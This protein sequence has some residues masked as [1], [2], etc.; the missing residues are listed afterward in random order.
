MKVST[1]DF[2]SIVPATQVSTNK[3]FKHT[4]SKA[5][6]S[7]DKYSNE[8]AEAFYACQLEVAKA[9]YAAINRA[10]PLLERKTNPKLNERALS[11]QAE[12][13]GFIN[14]YRNNVRNEI[15][16]FAVLKKH[17][18]PYFDE[19]D[20]PTSD[21]RKL[22]TG[23]FHVYRK[24]LID[25]APLLIPVDEVDSLITVINTVFPDELARLEHHLSFYEADC[26][27]KTEEE[28]LNR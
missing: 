2:F 4:K 10:Y 16:P 19:E 17:P 21:L 27:Y 20:R 18:E 12:V 6:V 15:L 11:A 13:K 8:I 5:T 14:R 22:I 7:L 26:R 23:Q 28:W 1:H 25:F 3:I 24:K 9:P